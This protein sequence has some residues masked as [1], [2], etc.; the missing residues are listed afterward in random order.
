M[1][2]DAWIVLALLLMIVGAVALVAVAGTSVEQPPRHDDTPR[3]VRLVPRI[4]DW[5]R[6]ASA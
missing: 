3:N 6:E 4:Y 5:Q 1:T 2:S